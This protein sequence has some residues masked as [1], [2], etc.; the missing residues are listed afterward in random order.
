MEGIADTRL[1][2]RLRSCSSVLA[3]FQQRTISWVIFLIQLGDLCLAEGQLI[4]LIIN[5]HN[6]LKNGFGFQLRSTE[7]PLLA[8]NVEFFFRL[9]QLA[10]HFR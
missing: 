4:E 2:R 1:F 7:S 3:F 9:V 10:A 8:I 5:V 6:L